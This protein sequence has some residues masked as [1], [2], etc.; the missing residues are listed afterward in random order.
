MAIV[1][2]HHEVL[3]CGFAGNDG[4]HMA[5]ILPQDLH[6]EAW[7]VVQWRYFDVVAQLGRFDENGSDS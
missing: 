3:R 2:I 1:V 5:S 7:C 6:H 4:M